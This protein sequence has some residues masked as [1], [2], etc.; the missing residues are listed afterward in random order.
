MLGP[1]TV[2]APASVLILALLALA[3]SARAEPPP[4]TAEDADVSARL[5]WIEGV[6]DRDEPRMR[7]W[8]SGWLGAYG[9]VTLAEGALFANAQTS[10][11]RIN[12]AIDAGKAAVGFT[13]V[14]VS[15]S[16]G[17]TAGTLLRALPEGTPAE[18]RAKLARGEA[19]LRASAKEEREGRGW[20]PLIGGALLNIG[21]AWLSWAT[22]KGS[23]GAGWF[24]LVSGVAVGE[25]QVV[26]MPSG[27]MRAWAAY[28]QRGSTARLGREPLPSVGLSFTPSVGGGTL[29]GWF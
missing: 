20:F 22:T 23:S 7:L 16:T 2:K 25:A 14:L 4:T 15:P 26:T 24:G 17:S 19:L 11:D 6:L 27:A 21:G 10:A 3:R 1:V 13:F 8:R 9:A 12:A 5:A 28:T 18:R 29:R